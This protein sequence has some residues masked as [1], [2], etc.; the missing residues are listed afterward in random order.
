M[1]LD[2]EDEAGSGAVNIAAECV[3]VLQPTTAYFVAAPRG[4]PSAVVSRTR[5]RQ[6][7]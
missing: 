2:A 1:K 4:Q 3:D 6:P 7:P 5:G